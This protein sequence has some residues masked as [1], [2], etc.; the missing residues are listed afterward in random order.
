MIN[1][2]IR[3]SRYQIIGHK[4]YRDR[5][6]IFPSRCSGVEYFIKK[7]IHSLPD[8][9]FVINTRDWP[10]ISHHFGPPLPV[11]SFSKVFILKILSILLLTNFITNI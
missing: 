6:C 10:Q 8:M 2:S 9:E 7:V 3:G 5:D 11:F 4:L 1:F